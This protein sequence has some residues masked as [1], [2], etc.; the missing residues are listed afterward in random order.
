MSPVPSLLPGLEG[1]RR[2]SRRRI[3][4]KNI[5]WEL[6]IIINIFVFIEHLLWAWL[7]T[8]IVSFDRSLAGKLG[9]EGERTGEVDGRN[10][11]LG[12]EK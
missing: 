10:E 9:R 4:N 11:E 12:K 8:G 3:R 5:P 6:M 2:A 7:F 1:K